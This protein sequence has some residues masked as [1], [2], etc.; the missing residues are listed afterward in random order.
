MFQL[1]YIDV[2]AII[3]VLIMAV[4]VIS[5]WKDDQFD[6]YLDELDA[7]L[8]EREA[9]KPTSVRWDKTSKVLEPLRWTKENGFNRAPTLEE[10]MRFTVDEQG[11]QLRKHV[12]TD[13]TLPSEWDTD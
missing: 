6:K 2:S 4:F 3:M 11:D 8:K 5:M 12:A 13:G 9:L 7:R 10:A 1:D